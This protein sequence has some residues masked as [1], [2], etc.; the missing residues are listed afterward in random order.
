MLQATVVTIAAISEDHHEYAA[1][2]FMISGT[3]KQED[4]ETHMILLQRAT[5]AIRTHIA[6]SGKRLYCI[7]SDGESRRGKA[8]GL[9]T[10]SLELKSSSPLYSLLHPLTLFNRLVGSDDLTCDKDWRHVLKRFRNA[11]L[12]ST[13][14]LVNGSSLTRALIKRHLTAVDGLRMCSSTADS[15]LSPNDPQDV[16]LAFRLLNSI[17]SLPPAPDDATPI[18]RNVRQSLTLLGRVYSRLLRCYTDITLTLREQLEHLSAVA[19]MLLALYTQDKGGFIPAI[20][21]LDAQIMIKNVYFCV[22]K[23][24]VDQPVD[25]KLWVISLGTDALEKVFGI[26]RTMIGSDANVDQLQLTNRVNG[27][28]QCSQILQE[29]P[30]WDR[31]PRRLAIPTLH[32]S[33]DVVS[34]T[35]DHVNPRSWV[36]DVSVKGIVLQTC[37]YCGR[38]LAAADL[39][40]F[41]VATTIVPTCENSWHDS[42]ESVP[43]SELTSSSFDVLRPFGDGKLVYLGGLRED[44]VVEEELQIPSPPSNAPPL[45]NLAPDS[46]LGSP[47][48]IDDTLPLEPDIEDLLGAEDIQT[49]LP[50]STPTFDPWLPVSDTPGAI[51]QHKS[52]FLRLLSESPGSYTSSSS[53]STDRLARVCGYTRYASS[54]VILDAEPAFG[55][56]SLGFDDPALTLLRVDGL[57]FLAVVQICEIKNGSQSVCSISLED[58]CSTAVRVRFEVLSIRPVPPSADNGNIDWEWTG[59]FEKFRSTMRLETEGKAIHPIDPELVLSST[60]RSATTQ[61]TYQFRTV[62]LRAQACGLFGAGLTQTSW[63]EVRSTDSFPYRSSTGTSA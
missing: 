62:E 53:G 15:L 47:S 49:Q 36:G 41:G 61:V 58:L 30:E 29:H 51:K 27:A 50:G 26:V 7:S 56:S 20:L 54:K 46:S 33:G 22:A 2:P 17:S 34:S 45:G 12:R 14:L 19:H 18:Y 43:G 3:C 32:N 44:D 35:T 13:P 4:A 6:P 25:G 52:T 39:A 16:I 38:Q 57:L 1:R 48:T 40:P 60:R 55:S 28:V 8:L 9:L 59:R 42:E 23:I 63:A 31:G 11:L 21:Y 5:T 37:W 10:M 24:L